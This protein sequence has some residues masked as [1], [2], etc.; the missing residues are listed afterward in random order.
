MRPTIMWAAHNMVHAACWAHAKRKF[1]QAVEL[2]PKV[3]VRATHLG[4]NLCTLPEYHA[5]M[6][7]IYK[8]KG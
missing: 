7:R 5:M 4:V 1:F 3:S 8:S 2:N 6:G